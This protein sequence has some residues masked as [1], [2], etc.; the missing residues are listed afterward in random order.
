MLKKEF[1]LLDEVVEEIGEDIVVQVVNENAK[2]KHVLTP[3]SAH[4]IVLMLEKIG[5]LNQNKN[6]LLKAKKVSNF[7]Y[8]HQWVLSL[9]W[10]S[11]GRHGILHDFSDYTNHLRI[12]ITITTNPSVFYSMKTTMP[13]VEVLR[14][15][16]G[17]QTPKMGFFMGRWTSAKKK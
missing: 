12:E 11:T 1:D 16:D 7:I 9:S 3:C 5:D 13:L 17:E 8:S 14:L 2:K 4:C 15:V 10:I 6:S